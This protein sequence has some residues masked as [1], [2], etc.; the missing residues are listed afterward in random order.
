[1][2]SHY[3]FQCCLLW[4]GLLG[5]NFSEIRTEI[6]LFSLKKMHLKLLSATMVAILS[7]V[8]DI[9]IDI[10]PFYIVIW[11]YNKKQWVTPPQYCPDWWL[12]YTE[13]KS[14][15]IVHPGISSWYGMMKITLTAYLLGLQIFFRPLEII[16][17]LR[18]VGF[19]GYEI[20]INPENT[21]Q[22]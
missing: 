2:R 5:T 21:L 10:Y 22:M 16:S 8:D 6:L 14:C 12:L 15:R 9:D 20:F 3:L 11:L 1:M 18:F 7:G 13:N 19:M 17:Q 4:I